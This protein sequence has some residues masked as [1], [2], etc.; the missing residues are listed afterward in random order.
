M[1]AVE[2]VKQDSSRKALDLTGFYRNIPPRFLLGDFSVFCM[3]TNF[4]SL[5]LL[6]PLPMSH[7]WLWAFDIKQRHPGAIS[8]THCSWV[9]LWAANVIHLVSVP[10]SELLSSC[11]FKDSLKIL[12]EKKM[13]G[14]NIHCQFL[15]PSEFVSAAITLIVQSVEG[16]LGAVRKHCS[17]R[18]VVHFKT[19][20]QPLA[21]LQVEFS[22]FLHHR[23]VH[24]KALWSLTLPLSLCFLSCDVS[25][26]S[27]TPINQV[28]VR[29][30]LN[31]S[32]H[33]HAFQTPKPVRAPC[34]SN[35]TSRPWS[36]TSLYFICSCVRTFCCSNL[37]TTMSVSV[38]LFTLHCLGTRS[39]ERGGGASKTLL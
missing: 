38:L 1:K 12:P 5:V 20:I 17:W 16:S 2:R 32:T 9:S 34:F 37:K 14:K 18:E 6:I 11:P 19:R 15:F 8:Y 7:F 4:Q 23:Y 21:G 28:V 24:S 36:Q 22:E 30:L 3:C 31:V 39:Q 13:S 29:D 33:C 35:Q 27:D 26:C 25:T 10:V